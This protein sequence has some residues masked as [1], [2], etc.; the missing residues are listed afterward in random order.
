MKRFFQRIDRAEYRE[1]VEA[2]A[3]Q[4][5]ENTTSPSS[6]IPPPRPVGRPPKKRAADEIVA[7]AASADA[8][9][10]EL[11]SNKRTRG[12]YTRWFSSP[13][14]NDILHT[15]ARCGYAARRTVKLLRKE[16]PDDRFDRL[17]HSTVSSWFNDSN[18]LTAKHQQ[19]LDEGAAS[20]TSL[21]PCSAL[22]SVPRAEE[23]ICDTL[24]QMREAGIPVNTSIVR[25]VM[26]AILEDK[27]PEVLEKLQL[28]Q[29][30][31]SRWVSS[32][33]RLQFSWRARTTT[34]SK[35]PPDWEDQGILMAKRIA[36]AIH[37]HKVSMDVEFPA[38]YLHSCPRAINLI[39][40]VAYVF[41][42][43]FF[44]IV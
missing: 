1:Q 29:S 38:T 39:S 16:A 19:E 44:P 25:W 14:I 7:D 35:L 9:R 10:V 27:H 31:I 24:L 15:H 23:Q 30:F 18:K 11:P 22:L 28:S 36:A 4:L 33:Q 3:E 12:S 37:L 6:S 40:S 26:Q 43:F 42:L 2:I 41:F 34:A 21:G 20:Q 17:S 5:K 13:Y 32:Q 8:L